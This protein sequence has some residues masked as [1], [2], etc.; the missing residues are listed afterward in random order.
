[1]P[2]LGHF[3]HVIEQE[4]SN[5]QAQTYVKL[6]AQK[7]RDQQVR[8][9][10]EQEIAILTATSKLLD[11]RRMDNRVVDQSLHKIIAT[12]T[13]REQ[14]ER[15]SKCTMARMEAQLGRLA[16]ANDLVLQ[17]IA[18]NPSD[19]EAQRILSDLQ[20][21]IRQTLDTAENLSLTDR[22]TLEG[23]YAFGQADYQTALTAWTKA[24]GSIPQT[25][26]P[27]DMTRQI[28]A[29][30]FEPYEKVAQA[31]VDE[32][33]RSAHTQALFAQGM[34]LYQQ[35]SYPGALDNFRQVAIINPDY[36][37]LG[38]YLVQSE[39]AAEKER[40]SRL[41]Q[42]K[43][44][45]ASE[46]F[47]R[48]LAALEKSQYAEAR[49]AFKQVLTE[50]PS[51]PKV[52]SYLSVVDTEMNRLHDPRAAQAHYESGLINYAS[53]NLEEAQREWR[54]ATKLDP[55]NEKAANALNKVE[56][57]IALYREVPG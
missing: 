29:L 38:A 30:H 25:L 40:T 57:E 35:G 41:T 6:I 28:A 37:Q 55:D 17:A 34:N 24:R 13:Q 56:K 1:M 11:S 14:A 54:I 4:P 49:Q 19:G 3:I 15:H 45:H 44:D 7:L 26:P 52:K 48:G 36:P 22:A 51:N 42:D 23:F 10:R 12:Q 21:Q 16:A 18:Q 9:A 2:A 20:S 43:K 46:D 47:A 5:E 27:D 39:A 33:S 31:H 32:E 50:D 8:Q 53:G